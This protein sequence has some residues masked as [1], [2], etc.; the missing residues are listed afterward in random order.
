MMKLSDVNAAT[1][2]IIQGFIRANAEDG[3]EV[4]LKKCLDAIQDECSDWAENL[5]DRT[6]LAPE[7]IN[8]EINGPRTPYNIRSAMKALASELTDLDGS[9][10]NID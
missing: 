4:A 3:E 5:D 7:K 8:V 1:A 10:V 9:V 2:L 6:A